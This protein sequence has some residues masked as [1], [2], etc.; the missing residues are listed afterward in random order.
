[1][2][3]SL[4][5]DP[6]PPHSYPQFVWRK[7][8]EM[9]CRSHTW[10]WIISTEESFGPYEQTWKEEEEEEEEGGMAGTRRALVCGHSPE[11][12]F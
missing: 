3:D 11:S 12:G 6:L 10:S 4:D 5:L 7:D 9:P 2:F 1:M 8:V